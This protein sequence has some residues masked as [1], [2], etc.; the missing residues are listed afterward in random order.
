MPFESAL[1]ISFPVPIDIVPPDKA[2]V[3]VPPAADKSPEKVPPPFTVK[4]VPSNL[5]Y[6]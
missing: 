1:K 5:T 3:N 2:P 4:V 6:L